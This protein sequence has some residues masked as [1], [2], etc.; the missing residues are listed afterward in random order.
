MKVGPDG[1]VYVLDFGVFNPTD[2]A[3]KVFPKTGRVYR[4]EPVTTR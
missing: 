3:M 2:K 4:I 1:L